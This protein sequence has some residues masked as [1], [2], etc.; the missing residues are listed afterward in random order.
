MV[1]KRQALQGT[2]LQMSKIGQVANYLYFNEYG[3]KN[4]Y[5]LTHNLATKKKENKR[6]FHLHIQRKKR[7]QQS[8]K[9]QQRHQ[10][11]NKVKEGKAK[12]HPSEI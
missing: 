12:Q 8:T 5:I 2:T 11:V 9:Q 4:F 7:R 6:G 3:K 10:F 1:K